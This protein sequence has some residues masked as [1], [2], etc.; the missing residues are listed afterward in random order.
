MKS[1]FLHLMIGALAVCGSA[2]AADLGQALEEFAGYEYGG[3]KKVLHDVRMSAFKGANDPAVR[4]KHE[5]Q[6]LEFVQSG[7]TLDARR[8]AC[9]WLSDLATDASVPVLKKLAAQDDFSDVAQIAL[10]ALV[11]AEPAA[12]DVATSAT[13]RLRAEVMASANKV[14]LLA[15]AMLG[16]DENLARA[17]LEMVGGGV[18]S[19]EAAAWL[20]DNIGKLSPGRQVVA[21]NVLLQLEAPERERVITQ[22][23]GSGSQVAKI[24]AIRSLG[25]L[26][27]KSDAVGLMAV[28]HSLDGEIAGAARAA[29][30]V[31]PDEA[32]EDSLLTGL[33][34]KEAATQAIAIGVVAARGAAFAGDELI[35]IAGEEGNPN[36]NAAAAA[37]GLVVSPDDFGKVLRLFAGAEGSPVG[38][39]L[40]ASVWTMARRQPDYGKA[41]K[42]L[43]AQGGKSSAKTKAS[44]ESMAKKLEA[45]QPKASLDQV[46]N[47]P[48]PADRFEGVLL[49]GKFDAATPKRFEVAAYLDCG[50]QRKV[51]QGGVTIECLNGKPWNSGAGTDPS[52]SVNFA[53]TSLDYAISGLESGTDYILG[54]TWWDTDRNGRRQAISINGREVLPDTRA[55]AYDEGKPTPTRIRFALLPEHIVGGSVQ[56][57][58]RNVE[59]P[60]AVNS[61]LWVMKRKQAA[62]EKQVLLV[63]GQDFKGHHWR[64]TGAVMAELIEVDPRM[65]V[66]ICETP[67]ALGLKH[68]DAYDVVFMHFKNYE[69]P[70]PSTKVMHENLDRYVR[71][72]GGMCLSHFA[73]GAMEEWP[74]FVELVGRVW[75]GQGHDKRGPFTVRVVDKEHQVTKGLSDFATDDELYFC[76][77]GSPEIHLLCDAHSKVKKADQPQA[78]VFHPGKGRVF[79]CTLGHDVKAYEAKEVKQLYRQ[80]T[81]WA[82]GLE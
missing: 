58:I 7:A 22:L 51:E 72:G 5:V 31:M 15:K 49:P 56:L 61:E 79:L 73:C 78:F 82:A 38:K 10:D 40:Q 77:K 71:S 1:I 6:L 34:D 47:P 8:E 18:A 62:A 14:D 36:R 80:A 9:Y 43:R 25:E 46:Q 32:V 24:A 19:K 30:S 55:L 11:K 29:L 59:G 48:P 17:A 63:S 39:E 28:A 26:G 42:M 50:P 33:K 16:D 70:L 52:L 35:R 37:L 23:T 75:N 21:M 81:A 4:A 44:L 2:M 20:A 12:G 60:N 68:L 66:T 27:R 57:S 53:A 67:Y 13:G 64:K 65:E 41:A 3:S 54:L 74:Q 76:L 45:L 69:G